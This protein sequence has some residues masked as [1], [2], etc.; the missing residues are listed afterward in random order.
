METVAFFLGGV[1]MALIFSF[2]TVAVIR[3]SYREIVVELCGNAQRAGYWIRASEICLVVITLLAAITFHGYR[4]LEP[5]AIALFWG[6]MS[7]M[8]RIL[9]AIFLSLIVISLVVL[10]SLPPGAKRIEVPGEHLP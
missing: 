10:R 1:A 5:G 4:T 6:L 8:A 3:K 2:A 9:A 7:Q